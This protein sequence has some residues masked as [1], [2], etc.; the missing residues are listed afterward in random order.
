MIFANIHGY[1]L[2]NLEI[3]VLILLWKLVLNFVIIKNITFEKSKLYKN[4]LFHKI[5]TPLNIL[6]DAYIHIIFEIR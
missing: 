2:I 1:S 4:T 6:V 5:T 3:F